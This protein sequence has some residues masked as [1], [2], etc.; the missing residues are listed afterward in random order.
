MSTDPDSFGPYLEGIGLTFHDN[1]ETW[2]IHYGVIE[3]LKHAL[4]LHGK[5]V[6]AFLVEPIQGKAGVTSKM[7]CCEHA[8]IRPDIVLPGK[9]LS[10][11]VY[12]VSAVL[13]DQEVMYCI[14]PGEY[15]STYGGEDLRKAVNI[16]AKCLNNL[17]RLNDI[18]GEVESEKGYKDMFI[19]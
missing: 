1:G 14:C 6:A 5:H 11:G 10:G 4:D 17:D 15:G 3:D 2:T 9:V 13:A 8:Q 19:N 16:I 7:L 12:P 18:P